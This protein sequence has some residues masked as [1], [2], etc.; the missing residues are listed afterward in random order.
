MK[1]NLF[2]FVE[3]NDSNKQFENHL[4]ASVLAQIFGGGNHANSV[5][6]VDDKLQ[7]CDPWTGCDAWNCAPDCR[8]QGNFALLIMEREH[9]SLKFPF[10]KRKFYVLV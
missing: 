7:F 10:L 2:T 6:K 1:K 5:T 9:I 8:C 3:R 4:C